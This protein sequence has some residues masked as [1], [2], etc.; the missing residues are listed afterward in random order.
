[1]IVRKKSLVLITV[2]LMVFVVFFFNFVSVYY[3]DEGKPEIEKMSANLE[4]EYINY[5]V[6]P[7]TNWGVYK[8]KIKVKGI[9][10]TGNTLAYD[11]RFYKLLDLVKTTE[12]NAMVIDVKDDLGRLTYKSNVD[13]VN[14][15][16]AD[17]QVKVDNFYEK[18]SI[19]RE[20]NI[21]P[22]ARIVTFKDRLAGTKRPDLAIKTK[23]GKVWRDNS[24]NAWLNPYN[25]EAWE[26]PIKIAEEAALMGFKEIQFDYVRFPT[27][28][29]RSIIDYG[30]ESI[31]KTKAEII[32][33]FLKYAK[34][35]LEP[36]GVYVSADIFGLVT[37]AKDDMRIGQH[38]ETLATSADILCPMVY[39]SHYALGSYGVAYPD[40]EPYKIV[41]TSLSRAKAR[42][43]NIK[44]EEAKAIIRPWLQDFS[45]P[46][47]KNLYGE[48]YINYG[49]EQIRAQIKAVYDAGLEEWIFWNASNRYTGAGFEKNTNDTVDQ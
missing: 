43:D 28:G 4:L 11:K 21:Y 5:L 12:L 17:K 25:R 34:E 49:P 23:N 19:L 36:K 24:G 7:A 29:N 31:G 45:A 33:E 9:Y 40:S 13:M 2:V 6:Q 16:G 38:L 39:P 15:I 37:T 41:Y 1:M 47:L 8:E 48:H 18:M 3:A 30:E 10:L 26:Y 32:A 27:D 42:I 20:N 22:I 35:R 44:T 14:E 46:W